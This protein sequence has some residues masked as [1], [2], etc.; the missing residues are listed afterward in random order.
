MHW[1]TIIAVVSLLW[2]LLST[3]TNAKGT[4][5]SMTLVALLFFTKVLH[6]SFGIFMLVYPFAFHKDW[7]FLFLAAYFGMV[8]SWLVFKK[9]CI[10]NYVE[11]NIVDPSYRLGDDPYLQSRVFPHVFVLL[12]VYWYLLSIFILHRYLRRYFNPHLS[13]I[14]TA[15]VSLFTTF[16]LIIHLAGITR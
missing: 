9:E 14:S 2:G 10:F 3:Y 5:L 6:A 15:L 12:H 8:L 4:G 7:D 1:L 13:S 11:S 16:N